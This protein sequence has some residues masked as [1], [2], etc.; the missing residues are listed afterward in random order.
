[1][2]DEQL[3]LTRRKADRTGRPAAGDANAARRRRVARS[4][5]EEAVTPSPAA[6]GEAGGED[7]PDAATD[8]AGT[9]DATATEEA[10]TQ[11]TGT[12]TEEAAPQETVTDVSA[13]DE[14]IEAASAPAS[15]EA[16]NAD[17]R[18]DS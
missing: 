15:D 10:A 14:P 16:S 5:G 7:A 17:E 3:E 11:V 2:S 9:T 12:A 18:E 4:R 1:M 13:D 8:D 6:L